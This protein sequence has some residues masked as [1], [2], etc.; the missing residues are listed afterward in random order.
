[1]FENV[2][3][4]YQI[5]HPDKIYGNSGGRLGIWIQKIMQNGKIF[6]NLPNIKYIQKID[7]SALQSALPFQFE[8]N[9]K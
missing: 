6:E 5:K 4:E 8:S 9:S 7:W 1:M 3:A 2:P